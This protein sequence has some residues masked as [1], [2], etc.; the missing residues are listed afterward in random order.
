MNKLTTLFSTS[1]LILMSLVGGACTGFAEGPTVSLV[2]SLKKISN[3]WQV[4]EAAVNGI[5]VTA[6]YKDDFFDFKDNGEYKTLDAAR[7]VSL[8]PYTEDEIVPMVG[9]GEWNFLDNNL[10]ELLYTYDFPDPYNSSVRYSEQVYERWEIARLTQDRLWLR[11]DSLLL[12]M[13]FF[14]Q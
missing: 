4:K 12:K 10:I 8:P 13:E 1:V 7:L 9:E 3:T 2:S 14:V 5:D 6:R 11:N